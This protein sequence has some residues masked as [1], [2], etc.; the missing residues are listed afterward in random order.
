MTTM[1]V[2]V[3]PVIKDGYWW[4]YDNNNNG[5]PC[6]FDTAIM[7]MGRHGSYFSSLRKALVSFPSWASELLLF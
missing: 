5:P 1:F 6:R 2:V 7:G 4:K 3:S